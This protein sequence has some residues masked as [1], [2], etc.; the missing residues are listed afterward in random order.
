MGYIVIFRRH[1]FINLSLYIV[2]F[3]I[4]TIIII[5]LGMLLLNQIK[6]VMF[7]FILVINLINIYAISL[8]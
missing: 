4:A 7:L 1:E 5:Y 2:F 3:P 6:C 8:L